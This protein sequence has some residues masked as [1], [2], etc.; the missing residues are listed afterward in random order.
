MTILVFGAR[1]SIIPIIVASHAASENNTSGSGN[2]ILDGIYVF[3][4]VILIKIF[5]DIMGD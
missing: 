3:L 5:F 2:L 1:A 4:L